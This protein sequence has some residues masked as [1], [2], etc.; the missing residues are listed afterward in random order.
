MRPSLRAYLSALALVAGSTVWASSAAAQGSQQL[1]LTPSQQQ[2]VTQGLA[3]QPAQQNLQGSSGQVGSKVSPSESA[4]PLPSDVQAQVP[5]A[6]AMLF[7]KLPDRILLID[8]DS[9]AVA[10]IVMA[11][12]T[13]GN[14]PAPAQQRND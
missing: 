12:S 7:V 14:A 5:D 1:N 3:N 13:T 6:K 9:R 8:P 4:K 10:E 11:P 2:A